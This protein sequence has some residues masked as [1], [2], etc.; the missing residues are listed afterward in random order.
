MRPVFETLEDFVER[1]SALIGSP[2]QVIEKV[3]RYHE[4]F[5]HTVLHLHADAGGLSWPQHR[6]SMELFQSDIAPVLRREIPDPPWG[7]GG[8]PLGD[9]AV[10]ASTATA[11]TG[12]HP[13]AASP[14]ATT[15]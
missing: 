3:H 12:S 2:A 15:G 13:A 1:S 10:P 14:V 6:D 8:G 5:G 11:D 9:D 4:Q 7:W